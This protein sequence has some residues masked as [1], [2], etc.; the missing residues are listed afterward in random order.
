MGKGSSPR[1]C[2]SQAFRDNHDAIDWRHEEYS[3]ME[4][5]DKW[6]VVPVG[7]ELV[8]AHW[9]DAKLGL[10][11][12]PADFDPAEIDNPSRIVFTNWRIR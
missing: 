9:R 10:R 6:Y 8:F 4:G 12:M 5:G 3:L 11:H 7:E 1:N 2:F